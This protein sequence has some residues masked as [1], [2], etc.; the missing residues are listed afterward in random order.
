MNR[1]CVFCGSSPGHNPVY[2]ALA[3]QLGQALAQRGIGLVY[4]GGRVGLMGVVADA[5]L[6]A[7]GKVIGVIPKA[8]MDRELGHGGAT[9]L[10]V[11]D[12][13]HERKALM[14]E[15][16]DGFVALPG[17][18]GTLEEIFEVWTWAQLGIH[19]KPCGLLDVNGFFS[20]LVGFLDQ[21]VA[22]GFL[23]PAARSMLTVAQST[24]ELFAQ[25]AAYKAPAV[26]NWV[27]SAQT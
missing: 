19:R 6:A 18:I 24:D 16:A 21:V 12:S 27:T 11:V 14:A 7:G 17:G 3:T 9:E 25:L 5:T 20:P 23:S 4:G 10:R 22:N 26:Q 2:A 8:L 15:L 1:L 13:M